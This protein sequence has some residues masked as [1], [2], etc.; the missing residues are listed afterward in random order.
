MKSCFRSGPALFLRSVERPSQRVPSA[1][2]TSRPRTCSRIMP[3]RST[4]M[5][6][7][8]VETRPPIWQEPCEPIVTGRKRSCGG[9]RVLDRLQ[10]AAGLGGR[11]VVVGVDGADAVEPAEAEADLGGVVRGRAEHQPGVAALR[12]DAEAE[13][14]AG[15]DHG[16]DLGDVAGAE[17]RQRGAGVV[18]E[19][20]GEVGGHGV[21]LGQHRP[22]PEAL[23][24]RRP[25]VHRVPP[26]R[27]DLTTGAP[28]AGQAPGVLAKGGREGGHARSDH[29]RGGHDRGEAR[30][31]AR[32]RAGRGHAADA[33]RRGAAG[34]AG[35]RTPVDGGHARSARRGGGG[36]AG[37]RSGRR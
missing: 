3:Q 21:G 13:A 4:L 15:A 33:G 26:C 5:P 23:H 30:A 37:R 29:R 35:R 27:C 28:V 31:L 14:G 8:L 19:P 25:R 6:P 24:Q 36:G 2:T 32:R 7:A 20:V 17:D 34:G 9:G 11:G 1:S 18:A 12:H 16:L 10:H 22:R